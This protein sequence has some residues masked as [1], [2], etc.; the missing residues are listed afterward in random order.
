MIL[1]GSLHLFLQFK[2]DPL[3]GAAGGHLP[4]RDCRSPPQ[5][6]CCIPVWEHLWMDESKPRP[7]HARSLSACG[8]GWRQKLRNVLC[9]SHMCSLSS[10]SCTE[11]WSGWAFCPSPGLE[12]EVRVSKT[13]WAPKMLLDVKFSE[14]D[15]RK[16]TGCICSY[17]KKP[18]NCVE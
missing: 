1:F 8:G 5:Q 10:N 9:P 3:E 4:N 17:F 15:S 6:A 7:W 11:G 16:Y 2:C 12:V 18:P 14:L 13:S